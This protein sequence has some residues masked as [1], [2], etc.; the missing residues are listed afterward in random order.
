M[1][2]TDAKVA[3]APPHVLNPGLKFTLELGPLAVFFLAYW[4]YDM[5]VATG[6]L[7]VAVVAILIVSYLLLR[8]IPTMPLVTTIVVVIFG[9]LT[10]VLH[11]AAFIKIKVSALYLLFSG[12]LFGGLF[13][14]KLLLP[15]VFD[16]AFHITQEGWRK[17]TY[18]WGYFFLALAALNLIVWYVGYAWYGNSDN[19]WVAFKTFGI[20]PLTVLFAL[21]Q[22]PLIVRYESKDAADDAL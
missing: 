4:K 8:R 5:F 10:L 12:A 16:S 18:R 15:I 19:L 20:L 21:A 9:G 14:N 11:D 22:T 6:A 3:T 13:F 1:N 2:E 7:M 17:L